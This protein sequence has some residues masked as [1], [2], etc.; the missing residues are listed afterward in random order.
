MNKNYLIVGGAS[1]IVLILIISIIMIIM[2]SNA[3]KTENFTPALP[4][5]YTGGSFMVID[6]DGNIDTLAISELESRIDKI[7]SD[8]ATHR[9]A[10]TAGLAAER[11]WARVRREDLNNKINNFFTDGGRSITLNASV[12][13]QPRT[14][15]SNK[16]LRILTGET[17]FKIKN[18]GNEDQNK[19]LLYDRNSNE[20]K[21]AEDSYA[22]SP[23]GDPGRQKQGN[24]NIVAL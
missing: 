18:N 7:A 21:W 22:T 14:T 2:N 10:T 3:D 13:G 23:G 19:I 11:E 17:Q 16:Q 6:K 24:F 12:S 15:I 20:A 8:L 4:S 5:K 1:L 9:A